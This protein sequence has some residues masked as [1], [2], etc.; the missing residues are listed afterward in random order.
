MDRVR[1][2]E[3]QGKRIILLDFSGM[4]D[5]VQG[6]AVI[7]EATRLIGTQP[8]GGGTLT[9]TDVT[10]TIYTRQIIEAFKEMTIRNRPFVKAAAI[11][12]NSTLHRAA[13]GMVALFSRRK[14][15]V[16]DSRAQALD[17]LATRG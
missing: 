5:A 13:I 17:W 10:D 16:C 7:A 6:L 1:F 9:L 15:E 8:V 12:S 4:T 14:L 3:H 2:V 11:V